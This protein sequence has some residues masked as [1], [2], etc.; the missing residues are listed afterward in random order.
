MSKYKINKNK[1]LPTDEKIRSHMD[2]NKLVGDYNKIHNYKNATRPLYKN[3]KFLGFIA[4]L[5]TVILVFIISER[6]NEQQVITNKTNTDSSL[7]VQSKGNEK[8]SGSVTNSKKLQ[9][10]LS[11]PDTGKTSLQDK[12]N[13]LAQLQVPYKSYS[14]DPKLGSMIYRKNGTRI[15][16]PPNCFIDQNGNEITQQIRIDY[17]EFKDPVDY[18][19]SGISMNYDSAGI[20]SSLESAGMFEI[21]GFIGEKPVFIKK[22]NPIRVELLTASRRPSFNTYYYDKQNQKWIYKGQEESFIRFTVEADEKEYPELKPFKNML[23]EFS[24]N[25]EQKNP[26]EYMWIFNRAWNKFFISEL[27]SKADKKVELHQTKNV[28]F[29][30]KPVALLNDKEANEKLIKSKFEEYY[31]LISKKKSL[32]AIE[33][34]QLEDAIERQAAF[35]NSDFGKTYAAWAKTVDGKRQIMASKVTNLFTVENF[36]IYNCDQPQK[37]PQGASL[38]VNFKDE[39]NSPL[40]ISNAM[41]V[42]HELNSIF[43]INDLNSKPLMYNPKSSNVL[44]QVLPDQKLAIYSKDKFKTMQKAAGSTTLIMK[45]IDLKG[46]N[47]DEVRKELGIRTRIID[48]ENRNSNY[49]NIKPNQTSDYERIIKMR[50]DKK[51]EDV[52][53][54]Q[55]MSN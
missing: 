51:E 21:L 19:F 52:Y 26:S 12:D 36:G 53:Y 37:Y 55:P 9:Q 43:Y 34:K 35:S 47:L 27:P 5:S 38:Q 48:E 29:S 16:I 15:L 13:R 11:L 44:W 18:F 39:N 6:E 23:W 7:T 33:N 25:S 3:P 1:P 45:I 8:D 49:D 4:L 2:F 54:E 31:L 40:A 22:G 14:V 42:D 50:K 10:N 32:K 24:V 28:K 20:H 46:K 30:A 17:R 41:L